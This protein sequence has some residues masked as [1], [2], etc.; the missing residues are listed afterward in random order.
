[1]LKG[2][3]LYINLTEVEGDTVKSTA[4]FLVVALVG[5][6]VGALGVSA[7]A[8]ALSFSCPPT[9]T[10]DLHNSNVPAWTGNIHVHMDVD[11]SGATT[12]LKFFL[13]SQSVVTNTFKALVDIAYQPDGQGTIAPNSLPTW[14]YTANANADGFG[15]FANTYHASNVAQGGFGTA[16]NPVVVTLGSLIHD[17]DSVGQNH[18]G[19]F[20]AQVIFFAGG[21]SCS[22]WVSDGTNATPASV[23]T[24]CVSAVPEPASLLLMGSGLATLGVL[25]RKKLFKTKR[26]A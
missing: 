12:I 5:L 22:G 21:L 10:E 16:A 24:G 8:H 2:D 15:R 18:G 4:K 9:C 25:V 23:E 13:D 26:R 7:P 1:V 6:A 19:I 17:F 20:A 3:A 14:S 11:N